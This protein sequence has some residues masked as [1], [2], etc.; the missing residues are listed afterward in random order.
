[1]TNILVSTHDIRCKKQVYYVFVSNNHYW[2]TPYRFLES[3]HEPIPSTC[4]FSVGLVW[5]LYR[6]HR[7]LLGWQS[8]ISNSV[9][10]ATVWTTLR[11]EMKRGLQ[12]PERVPSRGIGKQIMTMFPSAWQLVCISR[13]TFLCHFLFQWPF[14]ATSFRGAGNQKWLKFYNLR[15]YLTYVSAGM[16]LCSHVNYSMYVCILIHT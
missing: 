13:V 5:A 11:A 14:S 8:Q 16:I 10:I 6:M 9:F 7:G 4:L 2:F 3:S 1:M 12:L 15:D